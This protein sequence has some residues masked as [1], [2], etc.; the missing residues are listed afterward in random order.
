MLDVDF[1]KGLVW[2][3]LLLVG[4]LRLVRQ[5]PSAWWEAPFLLIVISLSELMEMQLR[6]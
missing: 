2:A 4:L 6:T 1:L 3:L 5:M